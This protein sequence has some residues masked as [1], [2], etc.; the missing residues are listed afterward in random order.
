VIKEC[1]YKKVRDEQYQFSAVFALVKKWC[2]NASCERYVIVMITGT[3]TK[4]HSTK[5]GLRHCKLLQ[6]AA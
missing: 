6:I 3:I 5:Q 4:R 2:T 1:K